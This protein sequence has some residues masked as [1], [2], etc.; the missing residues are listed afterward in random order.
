[1]NSERDASFSERGSIMKVWNGPM[2]VLI[3]MAACVGLPF[4]SAR[5]LIISCLYDAVVHCVMQRTQ[6]IK[7]PVYRGCSE[8]D[9]LSLT[10]AGELFYRQRTVST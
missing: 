6:Q 5:Y 10:H 7:F 3:Y 8:T 4:S 1:M 2:D 9:I